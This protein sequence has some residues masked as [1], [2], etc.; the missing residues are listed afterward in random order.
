M[1]AQHPSGG[2]D[3]SGTEIAWRVCVCVVP[4]ALAWVMAGLRSPD[5]I[6]AVLVGVLF[7]P[8]AV[9]F[10]MIV[11]LDTTFRRR[12]LRR[13]VAMAAAPAVIL[14]VTAGRVDWVGS[15]TGAIGIVF[16]AAGLLVA[17]LA[18]FVVF[19]L[20]EAAW[21]R[22]FPARACQ[23]CGYSRAGLAADAPCPECGAE[24]K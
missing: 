7:A 9:P 15:S 21:R 2:S 5:A 19:A 11:L 24:P 10:L 1:D 6:S 4:L 17:G 20:G 8:L 14:I 22:P 18:G 16:L 13:T 3:W 23:A 12:S